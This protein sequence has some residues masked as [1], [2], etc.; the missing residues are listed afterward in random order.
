MADRHDYV[1]LEWL[2]GEIAETLRQARNEL[3]AF[4]EDPA[5]SAAMAECLNLVHQVHGSLQMIEFYGAALLA[6]EIEQLALA[7][8]QNRV[9]HPAES[10]QLLIQAMSQ[11]PVYL[12][13]IHSARRD[14]PLVVLPL[15]NDLRSARGESLLSETSLFAPQLVV[16]PAL[17]DQELARRNTPELPNLLRKLR[18]TLQAALAGLM[19][20]QGVQTQLGYMAKVFARL[21]QLCEDAPL[22]PLWRIASALVE[23][24]LNGNFTN[25]PALRSLL[26][27]A[28]KELKRLAEQGVTGINQPA[29]EE[30]LKSLLFYIAKS[31]S[32]APKMLDLKDQYALADALPGND[33]VNEE[34]ARM[35]GPD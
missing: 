11:L 22:G 23:T 2:K 6:E 33:V 9:S 34:R 20:E 19:R 1:A 24:M 10:E 32:L 15:L 27:D 18:Q 35:A 8:Q 26:K 31:D 21:E 25:S 4:I 12:E 29:P 13:R 30:L 16:V 3:D 14:L 5:N 17:D 28:D 7:V